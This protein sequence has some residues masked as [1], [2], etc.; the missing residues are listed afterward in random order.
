MECQEL[1]KEK[2]K[3]GARK[4]RSKYDPKESDHNSP[5]AHVGSRSVCRVGWFL[6][7]LVFLL[8]THVATLCVVGLFQ[9]QHALCGLYAS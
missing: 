3:P 7:T 5:Y 6:L 9:S 2:W 8:S 4:A 1:G